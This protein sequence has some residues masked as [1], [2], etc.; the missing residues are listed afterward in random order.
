MRLRNCIF[1]NSEMPLCQLIVYQKHFRLGIIICQ[2]NIIY[3]LWITLNWF[4]VYLSS[5]STH[6]KGNWPYDLHAEATQKY[7]SIKHNSHKYVTT[8]MSLIVFQTAVCLRLSFRKV[9]K[10]RTDELSS[11]EVEPVLATSIEMTRVS[12]L[13][14]VC[15]V[16][17]IPSK[18]IRSPLQ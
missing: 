13:L 15:W 17:P 4:H 14:Q 6:G 11:A 1:S 3:N 18:R 9:L 16:R 5:N 8:D 2:F 12:L 10:G 7:K